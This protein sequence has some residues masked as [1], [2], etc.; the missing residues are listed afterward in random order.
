MKEWL[1][2]KVFSECIRLHQEVVTL[3]LTEPAPSAKLVNSRTIPGKGAVSLRFPG[4]FR[5][6]AVWTMSSSSTLGTGHET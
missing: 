4:S 5:I 2:L 1:S 6:C 3:R